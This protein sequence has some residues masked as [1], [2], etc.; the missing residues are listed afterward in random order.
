M[1]NCIG[2]H[3]DE[4]TIEFADALGSESNIDWTSGKF[5]FR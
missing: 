3:Q 5:V 4:S 1:V 2:S